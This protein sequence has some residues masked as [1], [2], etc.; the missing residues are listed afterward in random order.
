MV[1]LHMQCAHLQVM[2]WKA[3]DEGGRLQRP[4]TLLNLAGRLLIDGLSFPL[5]KLELH[6]L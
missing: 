3:A 1:M 4:E 2:V 6:N 5:F